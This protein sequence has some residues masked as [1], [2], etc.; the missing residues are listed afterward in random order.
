MGKT[1]IKRQRYTQKF[2]KNCPKTGENNEWK[3]IFIILIYKWFS[4]IDSLTMTTATA[5]TTTKIAYF[6]LI[7]KC[8]NLTILNF[9]DFVFIIYF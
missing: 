3:L 9:I 2:I 8:F 1:R 6:N 4:F 7:I 5:T